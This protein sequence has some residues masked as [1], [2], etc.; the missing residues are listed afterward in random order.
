MDAQTIAEALE[1]R[2]YGESWCGPC[3]CCGGGKGSTKFSVKD[4]NNGTP[5]VHCFGGCTFE[6]LNADLRRRGLWP[7]GTPYQYEKSRRNK[8]Q[9]D[10]EHAE[11]ILM[12]AQIDRGCLVQDRI[13]RNTLET[14]RLLREVGYEL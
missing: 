8:T 4:G 9:R 7:N 3:P 6:A 12:L 5:L 11:T 10:I 1:L 2:R 14:Q 13:L